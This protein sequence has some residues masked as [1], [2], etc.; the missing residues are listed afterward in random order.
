MTADELKAAMDRSGFS[1][2]ALA[3][4]GI[5][6]RRTIHYWLERGTPSRMA[7]LALA[8]VLECEGKTE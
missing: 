7:D 5:A 8:H 4:T 1:A 2:T 6:S 3:R